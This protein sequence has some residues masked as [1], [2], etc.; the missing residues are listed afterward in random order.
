MK[1]DG[2][3]HCGLITYEAEID[4]D[5]VEVCHCTDCQ[6]FSGSAFRVGV[7]VPADKFSLSGEPTVYVK[8]TESGAR[9]IQTFCPRCG[10]PIYGAPA[11]VAPASY[12]L[13]VGTIRQR[14]ELLPKL[15]YWTRS[16]QQWVEDLASMPR[17]EK[18]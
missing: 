17:I 15:Q 1:I 14:N 16:A 3:C 18:Q 12:S 9:R 11:D 8:T 4:P 7:P 2:T 6:S 13:R 10:S 5:Q